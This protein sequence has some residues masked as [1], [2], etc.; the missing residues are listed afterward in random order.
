MVIEELAGHGR[1]LPSGVVAF[2]FS[3]IEGSTRLLATLGEA[4]KPLLADHR[5]LLRAVWAERDGA[6]V[7]TE[8]DSF[9]VAFAR[10]SDAIRAARDAQMALAGHDWGATSVRVRIGLH[11]GEASLEDDDYTGMAVHL[12]ARVSAAAHGGQVL[13][14]EACR[15]LGAEALGATLGTMDLGP[16]RLKDIPDEVA[17]HQLTGAGLRD[18][19]PPL[20]TME[21]YRTNP[22]RATDQ[23][24]RT[25]ERGE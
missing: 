21:R 10:P 17:L 9:F 15:A 3:D 12:A 23:L 22:A 1:A 6:E 16:H 25:R 14:T 18:D 19:F 20:R 8:G 11:A 4:Y 13:L 7:G 5:R 24:R 2:L